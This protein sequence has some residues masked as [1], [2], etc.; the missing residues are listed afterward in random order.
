MM[1]PPTTTTRC[2]GGR[3]VL[4]PA[5]DLRGRD[6]VVGQV[7]ARGERRQGHRRHQAAARVSA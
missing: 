2:A 4:G 5:D 7:L 3:V 6:P 1:P